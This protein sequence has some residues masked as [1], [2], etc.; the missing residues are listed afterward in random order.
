MTAKG[1]FFFLIRRSADETRDKIHKVFELRSR[2]K[3][4]SD[5]RVVDLRKQNPKLAVRKAE[6]LPD[7]YL[8]IF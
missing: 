6:S 4:D 2:W 3:S 8:E 1:F 7:L 5:L